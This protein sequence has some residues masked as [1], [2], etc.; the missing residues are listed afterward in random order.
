MKNCSQIVPAKEEHFRR[1]LLDIRSS[2]G[3]CEALSLAAA[4]KKLKFLIFS[5]QYFSY[6]NFEIFIFLIIFHDSDLYL[7][8]FMTLET[9]KIIILIDFKSKYLKF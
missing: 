8:H 3:W 6:Q 1:P 5:I 2:K 7:K 4:T 9:N